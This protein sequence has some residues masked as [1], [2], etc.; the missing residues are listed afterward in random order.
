[1]FKEL[2]TVEKQ[3]CHQ[4][5]IEQLQHFKLIC[6]TWLY[7]DVFK[8]RRKVLYLFSEKFISVSSSKKFSKL[9]NNR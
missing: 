4:G 5:M 1:V 3:L 8:K 2:K 9:I 7:S 6:F